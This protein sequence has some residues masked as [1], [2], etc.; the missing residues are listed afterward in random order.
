[1]RF[2][3][4]SYIHQHLLYSLKLQCSP[5]PPIILSQME[6]FKS[7][8]SPSGQRYKLWGD[9]REDKTH[10]QHKILL[11]T[12]LAAAHGD[13]CAF[14]ILHLQG[15]VCVKFLCREQSNIISH[16]TGYT[17]PQDSG[18]KR[19]QLTLWSIELGFLHWK[20]MEKIFK[21][22]ITCW[23]MLSDRLGLSTMHITH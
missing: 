19:S 5:P 23:S 4:A 3:K 13:R 11:P 7:K 6:N 16:V 1:M 10:S 12:W 22:K 18:I 14:D 2:P 9:V 21:V 8:G 15:H 17:T 20:Q